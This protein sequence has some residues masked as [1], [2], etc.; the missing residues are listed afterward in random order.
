MFPIRWRAMD[1]RPQAPFQ[2]SQQGHGLWEQERSLDPWHQTSTA[3]MTKAIF[4]TAALCLLT[5]AQAQ[6]GTTPRTMT[7]NDV[8]DP[9]APRTSVYHTCL[10]NAGVETWKVLGLDAQQADRI[11]DLQARYKTSLNPPMEEKGTKG[12]ATAVKTPKATTAVPA[13]TKVSAVS[14]KDMQDT[15]QVRMADGSVEV[16]SPDMPPVTASV[17]DE[18]RTILTPE[19]LALWAKKCSVSEPTGALVPQE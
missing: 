13:S 10:V 7:T 14:G 18:L 12:K 16:T 8:Q 19:Q 1:D 5:L 6:E 15:T 2:Q 11:M 4:S 3:M 17:D 9:L